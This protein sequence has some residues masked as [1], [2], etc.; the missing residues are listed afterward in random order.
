[1]F[2]FIGRKENINWNYIEVLFYIFLF[3]N[4]SSVSNISGEII[5]LIYKGETDLVL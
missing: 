3:G 1:M 2:N 4:I 5:S